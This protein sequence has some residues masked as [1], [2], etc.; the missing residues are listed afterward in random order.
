VSRWPKARRS[1]GSAIAAEMFMNNAGSPCQ[2]IP[3]AL[4]TL[5]I[6]ELRHVRGTLA[7]EKTTLE[8]DTGS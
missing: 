7:M 1:S 6:D 3:T 2:W 5:A 4:R 8:E